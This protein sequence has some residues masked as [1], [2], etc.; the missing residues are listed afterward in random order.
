MSLGS[1]AARLNVDG[2]I[3]CGVRVAYASA[4]HGHIQVWMM[5]GAIRGLTK[6]NGV[7]VRT[8]PL[9]LKP[10]QKH[11]SGH[12]YMSKNTRSLVL[13]RKARQACYAKRHVIEVMLCRVGRTK[14]ERYGKDST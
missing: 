12:V 11:L 3:G 9:G 13:G 10:S 14:L 5:I 8:T 1:E 6:I 7:D 2:G 4:F